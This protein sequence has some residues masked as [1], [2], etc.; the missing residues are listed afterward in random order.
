MV[1]PSTK[2]TPAKAPRM[3]ATGVLYPPNSTGTVAY[4]FSERTSSKV[5]RPVKR[6]PSF[7]IIFEQYSSNSIVL[8]VEGAMEPTMAGV[9]TISSSGTS[10]TEISLISLPISKSLLK[11]KRPS[12]GDPPPPVPR[13]VVPRQRSEISTLFKSL[14]I[15]NPPK[16]MPPFY[17]HPLFCQFTRIEIVQKKPEKM[18]NL[19]NKPC[20]G[21]NPGIMK[22]RSL[23]NIIH[24]I[25]AILASIFLAFQVVIISTNV[26]MRYFFASGISWME[27]ISSNVLM[28]AFTFLSMAIGVKLDLHINV[29]LFPKGTPQW[30]TT[31]LL[32]LKH[33]VLAVIGFVLFYYGILLI[34]G[35]NGSIASIPSLPASLQFI[36]LPLAGFLIL[37][38]SIMSLLG[39]EKDNQYLDRKLMT[40][41]EKK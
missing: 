16:M 35:I 31:V 32:K 10:L 27:E 37:C 4:T 1:S 20:E 38:D 19:E 21:E 17:Q 33:L 24:L 23:F 25:S 41:G 3:A 5:F 36:M 22:I 2:G 9:T 15:P 30:V 8:S 7:E 40:A 11:M 34:M 18:K 28:T 6:G 12:S 39:V 29:N 14:A 13:T 26:I